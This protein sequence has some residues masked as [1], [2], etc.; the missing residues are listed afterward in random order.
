MPRKKISEH[1]NTA[2]TPKIVDI[3]KTV[4]PIELRKSQKETKPR[5]FVKNKALSQKI[6]QEVFELLVQGYKTY[7]II[8]IIKEK[9]HKQHKSIYNYLNKA[10]ELAKK[11]TKE[12][13]SE[14]RL[15]A[16]ARY[17]E[18]YFRLVQD[19]KYREAGYVQSLKDR[20]NGLQQQ[21]ID[22]KNSYTEDLKTLLNNILQK[23]EQEQ[24]EEGEK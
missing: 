20:I 18:L 14:L 7:K 2:K 22:V 17:D 16:N 13:I 10:Y 21:T 8:D 5:G 24:E 15:E 11:E 12:K 3:E 19:G 1:I 4:K 23:Q 6:I 9:Y